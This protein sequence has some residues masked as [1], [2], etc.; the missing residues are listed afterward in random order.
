VAP[1][2]IPDP[3]GR[4]LRGVG[5]FGWRW[6]R[7]D[8]VDAPLPPRI[9]TKVPPFAPMTIERLAGHLAEDADADRRWLLLLEFLEEYEH[10]SA[11]TRRSLVESEPAVVGDDRWDALLAG[12]AEWLAARD[13]F[14]APRWV[15]APKRTLVDAWCPHT[16]AS[17][18]RLAGK[19]PPLRSG[20]MGCS[21]TPTTSPGRERPAP[22]PS[23]APRG[24][25][26]PR[27]P[28]APSGRQRRA[29]PLRRRSH[30]PRPQRPGGDH[31]PR[32]RHSPRPRGG[33]DR[34][35]GRRHR[36]R[37]TRLVAQ[38]AGHCLSAGRSRRRGHD[39]PRP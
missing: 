2:W 33:H 7:S 38:R 29:V 37:P 11:P 12:V 16:L 8:D 17:L 9:R 35:T 32:R 24:A 39:D 13:H 34:G 36:A 23:P 5:R 1:H 31:G 6:A 3:A 25:G 19:T 20:V 22:Q 21:S 4:G 14:D 10:S 27:P 30:G 28:S 26:A 18:R 15:D